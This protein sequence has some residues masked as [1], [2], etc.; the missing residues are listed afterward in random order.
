MIT[1]DTP[2][3]A[4]TLPPGPD[5]SPGTRELRRVDVTPAPIRALIAELAIAEKWPTPAGYCHR[6]G[7][8]QCLGPDYACGHVQAPETLDRWLDRVAAHA[9]TYAGLIPDHEATTRAE[10]RRLREASAPLRRALADR[11]A[12]D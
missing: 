12:G 2:H 9:L 8:S 4:D 6:C 7:C 1:T 3:R 10:R 5:D 11:I